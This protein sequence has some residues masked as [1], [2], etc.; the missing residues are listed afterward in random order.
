MHGGIV[1]AVI[2]CVVVWHIRINWRDLWNA[3][4]YVQIYLVVVH[5][6]NMILHSNYSYTM[7]KPGSATILDLLG[8]WPW[9]ILSGEVV[10]MILF[11]LLLLP[12]LIFNRTS[13]TVQVNSEGAEQEN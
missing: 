4:I 6:I 3:V 12:F 5:L 11:L 7:A 9:Y 1:S 10:M 8:E 13:N 2:Y